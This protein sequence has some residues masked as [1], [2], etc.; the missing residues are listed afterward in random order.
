MIYKVF[1][2]KG[3]FEKYISKKNYFCK[4]Y[5][6]ILKGLYQNPISTLAMQIN[7]LTKL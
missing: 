1:Y 6:L 5:P 2:V 3:M 7:P 4:V